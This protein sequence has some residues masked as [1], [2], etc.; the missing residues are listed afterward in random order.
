[1][2]ERV[3]QACGGPLPT[4]HGNRKFCSERCR[5]E[6]YC[7]ACIDCGART[8]RHNGSRHNGPTGAAERC[9]PCANRHAIEIGRADMRRAHENRLRVVE[10][11]AGGLSMR[12]IA[13]VMG[14]SAH[15][16]GVEM[17][18]MRKLGYDLPHRR[19]PEQ[20]ARIREGR[21]G[22]AA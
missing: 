10:M 13:A 14:W 11:W 2:T 5:R 22:K 4:S 15:H 9:I 1:M 7:G 12:D 6:Q 17:H 21:W 20:R 18:R 8:N 19:T 16:L 3:C